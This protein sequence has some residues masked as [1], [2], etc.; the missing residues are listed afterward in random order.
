MAYEKARWAEYDGHLNTLIEEGILRASSSLTRLYEFLKSKNTRLIFVVSP[1]SS[2]MDYPDP[3]ARA[4]TVW[5]AWGQ[6]NDVPVLSLFA[7]FFRHAPEYAELVQS[8]GHWNER[9]HALVAEELIKQRKI[10]LPP[11]R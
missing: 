3:H 2:Q 9:G 6:A 8:S 7:L 10:F 5:E 4:L 1:G 11:A